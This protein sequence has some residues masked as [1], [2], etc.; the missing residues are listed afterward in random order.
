MGPRYFLL[1]DQVHI[2]RKNFLSFYEYF[3]QRNVD[4]L[5]PKDAILLVDSFGDYS[6][7]DEILKDKIVELSQLSFDE[8]YELRYRGVRVFEI[9]RP[10]LMSFLCSKPDWIGI[11][12][13]NNIKDVFDLAVK[14][15][16]A[17]LISN[18]AVAYY[19]LEYW[20]SKVNSLPKLSY[21]GIFSGS[22]IY[23]K[24]LI[25]ISKFCEARTFIF[26]SFFNGT[27][28]Y[29][30]EKYGP[31]ANLSDIRL[32]SVLKSLP[33]PNSPGAIRFARKQAIEK[34][35][36]KKNKNVLRVE[37]KNVRVFSEDKNSVLILGQVINDFSLL[38]F[39]ETGVS[40]VFLYKQI[41]DLIL[42]KTD[43]NIIFKG[44][45]WELKKHNL[46]SPV[47]TNWLAKNF[48]G[49]DRV[50]FLNDYSLDDLFSEVDCVICLNSQSGIEA[51]IQ[52]FKPYQIGKAFWGGNGF[53]N[54]LTLRELEL[55][56]NSITKSECWR[57][58]VDEYDK[59]LD[60][61]HKIT[62]HWL[63]PEKL[64]EERLRKI[65]HEVSKDFRVGT[66]NQENQTIKIEILRKKF[67]KLKRTP[68]LFLKDSNYLLFRLLGKLFR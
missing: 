58:S 30:E 51:A 68:K 29:C 31:I 41:I 13:G 14:T 67:L 27:H 9:V 55:I 49:Q 1:S 32:I 12:Y 24:A 18:Y 54:D 48:I 57:L 22:L 23:Q 47:T 15:Y 64:G 63:V 20:A 16:P 3:D 6:K 62:E 52:G 39:E 56:A 17:D 45:P 60:W 25:H 65:F 21:I 35:D 28:Y 33:Y 50:V 2:N 36:S 40:S 42:L 8:L 46:R 26:E 44:H 4:F 66:A 61:A 37:K 59:L 43:F 19:W 10:E 34:L 5:H 7:Y 38:E 11:S 53:S